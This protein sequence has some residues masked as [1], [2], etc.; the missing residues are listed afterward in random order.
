MITNTMIMPQD[1][2]PC[3]DYGAAMEAEANVAEVSEALDL[4]QQGKVSVE[5]C[6]DIEHLH[7][8]RKRWR[9]R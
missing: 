9:R 6:N 7:E 4:Y 2:E 5:E 8:Y 3:E 1:V